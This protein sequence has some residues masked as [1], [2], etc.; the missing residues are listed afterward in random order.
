ML[1]R[2]FSWHALRLTFVRVFAVETSS[3][4]GRSAFQTC[5]IFILNLDDSCLKYYGQ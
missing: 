4:A 1:N 2:H 3:M 5:S